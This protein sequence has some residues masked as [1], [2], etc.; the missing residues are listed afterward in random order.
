M[1]SALKSCAGICFSIIPEEEE[2]NFGAGF[3]LFS[4]LIF[5]LTGHNRPGLNQSYKKAR[6]G[7]YD[8]FEDTHRS[9]LEFLLVLFILELPPT[10]THTPASFW[11]FKLDVGEKIKT[12]CF[13]FCCVVLCSN[14]WKLRSDISSSTPFGVKQTNQPRRCVKNNNKNKKQV[15]ARTEL[16]ESVCACITYGE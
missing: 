4:C 3:P 15:Q 5:N 13:S 1:V 10:H 6:H 16:E 14:S 9:K 2:M 11:L 7:W 8:R 12:S